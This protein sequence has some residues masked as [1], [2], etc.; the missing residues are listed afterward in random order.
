MTILRAM[1]AANRDLLV[2]AY[3]LVFFILGVAV[4][5]Q[6]RRT[7]RLE[8]ARSLAW[9]AAFGILHGLHEWGDLFIPIQAAYLP[10]GTTNWLRVLQ[11]ALLVASFVCLFEFGLALFLSP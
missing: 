7:S 9:L 8:F 3:G 4:A 2:F 5:L 6:A 11:L 10:A 1:V